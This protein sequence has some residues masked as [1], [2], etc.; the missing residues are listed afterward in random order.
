MPCSA[1]CQT[2]IL[3]LCGPVIPTNNRII[4]HPPRQI[5]LA[6]SLCRGNVWTQEISITFIILLLSTSSIPKIDSPVTF[7]FEGKVFGSFF[8]QSCSKLLKGTHMSKFRPIDLSNTQK[9]S[10][11]VLTRNGQK[12]SVE[13]HSASSFFRSSRQS[14][15]STPFEAK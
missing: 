10:Y 7:I 8:P 4:A 3:T 12:S 14:R 11:Q 1:S 6:R 15:K 2:V 5:I 13:T 9:Y